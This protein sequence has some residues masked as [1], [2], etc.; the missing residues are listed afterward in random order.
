MNAEAFRRAVEAR[1]LRE[2]EERIVEARGHEL[3]VPD[4]FTPYAVRQRQEAKRLAQLA[5]LAPPEVQAER[6]AIAAAKYE[7][8]K[9]RFRKRYKDDSELAERMRA[10]ARAR[11]HRKKAERLAA[12]GATP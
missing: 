2:R 3:P 4:N 8:E 5:R 1:I 9:E 10:N 6:A 11:H 7:R 12:Q